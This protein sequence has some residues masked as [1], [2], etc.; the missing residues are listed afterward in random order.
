MKP[1]EQ[2]LRE[3]STPEVRVPYFKQRLRAR[4][5]DEWRRQQYPVY[6]FRGAFIATAGMAAV[7][8]MVSGAFVWRPE[9]AGR[10]NA[11]LAGNEPTEPTPTIAEA[12]PAEPR[13]PGPMAASP[14]VADTVHLSR[15]DMIP[16]ELNEELVRKLAEIEAKSGTV[17]VRPVGHY[18]MR[19][20]ELS[21]GQRI[22]VWDQAQP[23]AQAQPVIYY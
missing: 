10:M 6:S 14:M 20:Y 9:L 13:N 7:F 11:A 19:E 16:S 18:Q 22:R 17:D 15:Y 1:I 4:L 23:S 21:N 3:A 8:L 2:L 5:L 12:K